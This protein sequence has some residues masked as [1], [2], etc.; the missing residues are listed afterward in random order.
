MAVDHVA[1]GRVATRHL[2]ESGCRRVAFCTPESTGARACAKLR[3]EDQLSGY[4]EAL[5]EAGIDPGQG[6]SVALGSGSGA[7]EQM[8][9]ELRTRACN[10]LVAAT[11][12]LC[13][14]ML[15]AL[16][17]QGREC[18]EDLRLVGMG[19]TELSRLSSPAL[20]SV[21]FPEEKMGTDL[22]QSLVRMINSGV[23]ETDESLYAPS[24]AIRASS[25]VP[26]A[27]AAG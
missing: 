19:D 27:M 7:A 6:T 1:A 2:L 25:L 11:D 24:L 26:A 15:G 9:D 21:S 18:P 17:R 8:L 20:T 4:R 13:N 16:Q 3:D 12:R 14:H 22:I 23:Q 10:G 5:A